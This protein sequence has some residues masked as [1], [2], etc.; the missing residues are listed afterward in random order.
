MCEWGGQD[1]Q[2]GLGRLGCAELGVLPLVPVPPQPGWTAQLCGR[3]E[4]NEPVAAESSHP[5]A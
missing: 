3:V 2:G 4:A 1:V 5:P